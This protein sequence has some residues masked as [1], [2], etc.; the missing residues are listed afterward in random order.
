[1]AKGLEIPAG[2]LVD[3]TERSPQFAFPSDDR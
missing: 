2:A 1:V 3:N